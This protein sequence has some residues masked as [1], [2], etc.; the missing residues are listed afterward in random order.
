MAQ[1]IDTLLNEITTA[2]IFKEFPKP[3]ANFPHYFFQHFEVFVLDPDSPLNTLHIYDNTPFVVINSKIA[4]EFLEVS[5]STILRKNESTTV[6]S[7][8]D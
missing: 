5:D 6:A 2:D 7:N 3:G 1:V 8:V 4:G